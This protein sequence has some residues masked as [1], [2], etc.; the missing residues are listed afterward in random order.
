MSEYQFYEFQAIDRPLTPAEREA[1]GRLSSRVRPTATS[2]NF[3]YSYG[4]FPGDPLKVL[5][6]YFDVMYYIANWG[7][8]RLAFRFPKSLIAQQSIE[9]FLIEHCISLSFT[10]DWAILDWN[11]NKDEGFGWIEEESVLDDLLGLRQEIIQQDYRGLYLAWLKAITLSDEYVDLDDSQLEPPIPPGLAQLSVSQQA[12]SQIFELDQHLLTAAAIASGQP[13]TLSEQALQNAIAKLSPTDSAAFLLRLA[14]GEA[15]ISAKFLKKL[16]KSLSLSPSVSDYRRTIQQL[17]AATTQVA[18]NAKQ[19]QKKAAEAKRIQELQALAP[20]EG[21]VWAEIECLLE[22]SQAQNYDQAVKLLI[23]LRDLAHYQDQYPI[24]KIQL[25]RIHKQYHKRPG[26]I[27]RL[28][29]AGLRDP[30]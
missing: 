28:N 13:T 23:Q 7:T 25:G 14:Q 3:T 6:Q 30:D 18:E 16:S 20:R 8:Q 4:D 9:P 1:I 22:K 29:E 24:F 17:L 21:Q 2:A 15:N 10:Q 19:Q 27:R 26:F 12:F 11:F 5:A